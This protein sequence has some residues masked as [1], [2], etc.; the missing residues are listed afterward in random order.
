MPVVALLLAAWAAGAVTSSSQAPVG[1]GKASP[2]KSVCGLGTGKKATGKPI[3]IGAIVT[4]AVGVNWDE[5][6]DN[7]ARRTSTA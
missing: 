3:N 6:T 4:V 1:S 2:K 7:V 5:I